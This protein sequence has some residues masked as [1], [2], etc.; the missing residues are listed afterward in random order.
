MTQPPRQGG[1]IHDYTRDLTTDDLQRLFTRDTRDAYRFFARHI[2]F[3]QFDS[4][5]WYRRVLAQARVLFIAFTMRLSPAR[6]AVYAFALAATAVGLVNQ[7]GNH[8]LANGTG[9]L[10]LAFGLVN[11][12]VL[13]EVADRLSLKNDLEVA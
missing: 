4:L 13:L 11:L 5:A 7:L 6:R 9:W 12:L 2:D 10:L 8:G 3:R 1:F